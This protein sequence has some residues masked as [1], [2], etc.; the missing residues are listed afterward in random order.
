MCQSVAS[1]RMGRGIIRKMSFVHRCRI[2][3]NIASSPEEN[4]CETLKQKAT[5]KTQTLLKTSRKKRRKAIPKTENPTRN[6]PETKCFHF[7]YLV[8]WINFVYKWKFNR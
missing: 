7:M 4:T 3:T 2:S 8:F 6:K 5:V 1:T